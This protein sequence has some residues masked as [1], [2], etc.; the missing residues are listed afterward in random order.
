MGYDMYTPSGTYHRLNIWGMGECRDAMVKLG[1]L[2]L[3]ALPPEFPEWKEG[4]TSEEEDRY[5]EEMNDALGRVPTPTIGIAAY[6]LCSNDG[7]HVDP[8]EID[9]ALRHY[10]STSEEDREFVP[11]YFGEWIA[12]LRLASKDGGFSVY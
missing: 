5:N 1:M 12:F 11:S 2:D 6:K 4:F 3:T 10:D 8:D 9:E 7:W